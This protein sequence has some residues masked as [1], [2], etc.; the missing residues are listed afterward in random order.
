MKP[1]TYWVFWVL[2]SRA[3]VQSRVST[4]SEISSYVSHD[5]SRL[6]IDNRIQTNQALESRLI[7]CLKKLNFRKNDEA[8]TRD[9]RTRIKRLFREGSRKEA[10]H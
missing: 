2:E 7:R 1:S 9:N 4:T 10:R 8:N 6:K 3:S 5:L